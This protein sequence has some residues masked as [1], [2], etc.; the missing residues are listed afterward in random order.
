MISGIVTNMRI[1]ALHKS[2]SIAFLAVSIF[3]SGL[4]ADLVRAQSSA[5]ELMETLTPEEQAWLSENPDITLGFPTIFPPMVIKRNDGTH[6]GVLVDFL[7]VANRL[8]N[9]RIRLHV[10]D[11]WHKVWEGARNREFDGVALGGRDPKRAALFNETVALFKSY[12][13]VFGLARNEYQLKQFS[14]LDGM[15]I[16]YKA[17]SHPIKAMLEKLPSAVPKT[18]D[19]NESLTQA[20][21]SNEIDVVVVA[22]DYGRWLKDKWLGTTVDNLLLIDEYPLEMVA[23]IRKDWPELIS[24]L[25]KV[26]VAMQQDELPRII[27]K[28]FVDLPQQS[29][30]SRIHLTPEEKVWIDQKHTVRVRTVNYPPYQIIKNKEAPE[31]IAI[32]HLKLIQERTGIRFKYEVTDQP[33]A[34]FL[35]NMKQRQGPDMT[36]LISPTPERKQYLSF[37]EPYLS[38]IYVIFIREKD[39]PIFDIQGL[40]GKT[41]AVPRG[42]VVQQHL[43]SNYPRIKQALFDSDAK[44]LEAVATGQADAY[45]GSLTAATHIIHRQGFTGLRVA[46]PTPFKEQVL[47]MG[48]RKDWP[49]L[50][51]IIN[52]ALASITEEEKTAI[53]SKYLAIK[54]EQGINKAEVLKWVLLVGGSVLGILLFFVFWNRQMSREISRRKQTELA[55]KQAK[56]EL[57]PKSPTRPRA[58]FWPA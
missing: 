33:L 29:K 9:H 5:P 40:V 54:F 22:L 2:L 45:V 23:Y 46:A 14:D 11:P 39:N 49:E 4:S 43:E 56:D 42:F 3:I 6:V 16:G 34:E 35:E 37:T 24:I 20:M 55:L 32:E 21:L 47:S 26:I 18:Y 38:S 19:S 12:F 57:P 58:L 27:K 7:E 52:K 51:S 13:A 28:W 10:E 17:G 44:A 1:K 41:L 31:G 30:S 48:I 8:L 50:T 36:A 25:N 53:R 15:R